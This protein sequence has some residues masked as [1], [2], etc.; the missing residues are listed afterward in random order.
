MR[1]NDP[2]VFFTERRMVALTGLRARTLVELASILREVPGSAVFYHT[3]HMYLA[4]HFETPSFTNDFA[5]WVGEALQEQALAEKLAA[6][7]LLS[8]TSIRAL[9][10]LL[11]ATMEETIRANGARVRDCPPGDEFHF[12]RSKSF[13]MP[14]G[15]VAR[16]PAEFF[17]LV[18][19]ISNVSLFFHFFESRL[20]LERPTND[21]SQ[22][23]SGWGLDE[24]ARKIDGLD[25]YLVSLDELKR[26]V[27][28]A[29]KGLEA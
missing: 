17:E 2:F 18:P 13:I 22:W 11:I 14:T 1:Y 25:P 28:A 29:G 26:Q 15:L 10:E 3:H 16:H 23:L 4:H 20:R 21:F 19:H 27:A 5:L 9:R 7:D 12:C 8:F 24:L 6:V